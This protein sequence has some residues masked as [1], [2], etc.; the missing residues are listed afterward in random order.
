MWALQKNCKVSDK[1][2]DCVDCEKRYH[3]KCSDLSVDELIMIENG[4]NDWC[5]TNCKADC[6]LCS[7]AVLNGH[8]AVQCDG[9]ELWIINE[10]SFI[11]EDDYENV[12]TTRCTWICPKCD[13][14]NFSDSFFDD[15]LNLMTQNRFDPLSKDKNIGLSS[16]SSKETN[17]SNKTLDGLK[18]ISIN[19][20]SIRGKK[21][22]LLAFLE[23]HQPH[24]VAIQETKI[25]SS[26][27][28][29]ELFPETC[30]YN[31]FR[32]DRNLHGGGVM[33]L[34]HKD[35]P[36]MPLS[37]LENDSES[38]W[39]K[40]FANKTSHYVASWY[41]QPG[42]S[43]EEFQLFRDQLDH[44][45]TKHKG[46]KLPSVHVLGD[47]NFKDIAWPDR[48]NKSGS[49]LSHSEGQMLIDAMND[50]G[51]EQL[52][53]FPTREKNTLDLI[54]TSLPGQFQEI[55]SPDKLSDH[56]VIS[57]TLKIHIPPKKKPRRKV[58][59]YQKGNF[60]LMRE[61]ASGF[62]KDNTSMVTQT[63]ARF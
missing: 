50:H 16:K 49:L 20:N 52:V 29:S 34:I 21:L 63:I 56:D 62:A 14:F 8:K 27:A 54:L 7:R 47:F 19:I 28:T 60:E 32:K 41:R 43:S 22:D 38:V 13:F 10:C 23:V 42:G 12:L 59:L 6:G 39:A 25:D 36:H 9:C 33:L 53:H 61:D 4:S 46:N 51:L 35:S 55:H 57:G 31:I 11:S 2:I 44:I 30:Q 40:I 3:A 37:E 48:L 15:Q 18:L 17:P 24:V 45:R 26:I 5:C 58:F 1:V